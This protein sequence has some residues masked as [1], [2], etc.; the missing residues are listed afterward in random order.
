VAFIDYVR[1]CVDNLKKKQQSNILKHVGGFVAIMIWSRFFGFNFHN[2]PCSWEFIYSKMMKKVLTEIGNKQRYKLCNGES[3][4]NHLMD[5]PLKFN[6]FN[7]VI[8]PLV[9]QNKNNNNKNNNNNSDE[10]TQKINLAS[11]EED[12]ELKEPPHKKQKNSSTTYT[13]RYNDTQTVV[14][15]KNLG[16]RTGIGGKQVTMK[17]KII[18]I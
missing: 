2:G 10:N 18:V 8:K 17:V 14:K 16:M 1:K 11:S 15:T 6:K 7:Q 13:P 12:N 3:Q 5:T 4:Y 9:S